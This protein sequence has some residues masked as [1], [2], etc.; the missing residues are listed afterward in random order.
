MREANGQELIVLAAGRLAVAES[1]LTQALN[2]T[3]KS[4]RADKLMV[5]DRLRL[6]LAEILAAKRAL[7]ELLGNHPRIGG[8]APAAA[9]D[10]DG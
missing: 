1:E 8:E 9:P 3:P 2:D 4:Q 10:D 7:S 5:S 6:A